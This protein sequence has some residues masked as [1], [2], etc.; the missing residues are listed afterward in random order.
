MKPSHRPGARRV[1]ALLSIVTAVVTMS[2]CAARTEPATS[3]WAARRI[4][5]IVDHHQHL[6]SDRAKSQAPAALPLIDLPAP[7]ARVLEARNQVVVTGEPGDLFSADAIIRDPINGVWMQ[8]AEGIDEISGMYSS[9]TRFFANGYTLGADV[10]TITGVVRDGDLTSD[11]LHYAMGLER[12]ASGAWRIASETAGLLPTRV[13]AEEIDAADLI[14]IMDDIGIERAVV[15]SVAYWF[16]E[17]DGPV[18]ADELDITH[19]ENDWTAAQ[20]AR[21]PD[22]LTPICGI[23]PLRPYAEEEIRRCANEL[24]MPGIKMHFRSANV[25]LHDATHV[26]RI[27]RVFEV[28][29][30]LGLAIVVHA[31]TPDD[32][33]TYDRDDAEIFVDEILPAAPDVPVQIAHLWG[34]N[35]VAGEALAVY[36][37]LV[38]SGDPRGR[39]LYFDLAEIAHAARGNQ[40]SLALIARYMRQIGMDRMLYGSDAHASPELPPSTLGWGRIM[41]EVP[42]TEAE[43]RDI[44]DNVAPYIRR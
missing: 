20:A 27:R 28:A 44:A 32:F 38:S 31:E 18:T 29:N 25:N 34:G 5:P 15:L 39:N 19:W 37:E 30:E 13:F 11:W 16:G 26:A 40:E 42:L 36:A 35:E 1:A 6:M 8:G 24:G 17:G 43:F 23:A 21:Y 22:R 2:A 7:L 4:V 10:A 41:R 3:E 14:A 9:D 12:D 33:G